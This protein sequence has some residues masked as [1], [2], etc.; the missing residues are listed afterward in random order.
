MTEAFGGMG[1]SFRWVPSNPRWRSSELPTATEWETYQNPATSRAFFVS[2]RYRGYGRALSGIYGWGKFFPGGW[3]V[4]ANGGYIYSSEVDN[5]L[6]WGKTKPGSYVLA[7][8]AVSRKFD[9]GLLRLKANQY[10][11]QDTEADGEAV[12]RAPG[13][14][15]LA[16][17]AEGGQDFRLLLDLALHPSM[18]KPSSW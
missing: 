15:A 11:A 1:Y 5:G 4:T 10:I 12:F 9:N 2:S 17:H 13:S 7:G 18:G 8:L 16:F 3:N 14:T 6:A